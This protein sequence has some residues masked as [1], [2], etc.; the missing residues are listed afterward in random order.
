MGSL[1]LA[2]VVR[3]RE[4]LLKTFLSNRSYLK[5]I[6]IPFSSLSIYHSYRLL[7]FLN[8]L[9]PLKRISLSLEVRRVLVQWHVCALVEYMRSFIFYYTVLFSCFPLLFGYLFL[10]FG[11]FSVWT[12]SALHGTNLMRE[13]RNTP[14]SV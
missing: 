7:P 2:L 1:H 14:A 6:K 4:S 9:F 3:G 12:Y 8:P 10:L 13:K 11:L 5:S